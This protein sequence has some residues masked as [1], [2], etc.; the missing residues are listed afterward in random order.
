M[1]LR[2]IPSLIQI[3][4]DAI[5]AGADRPRRPNPLRAPTP[6]SKPSKTTQR[7]LVPLLA[8]VPTLGCAHVQKRY[9]TACENSYRLAQ[10]LDE[11][12]D[13]TSPLRTEAKRYYDPIHRA[14]WGE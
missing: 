1:P 14:C 7:I 3:I 11:H 13:P 8:I 2:L 10:M 12:L 5:R 6:K 9:E 4:I